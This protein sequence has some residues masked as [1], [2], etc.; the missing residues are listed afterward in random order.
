[1]EEN[2]FDCRIIGSPGLPPQDAVMVV[3]NQL[4]EI[5][6]TATVEFPDM[7][8]YISYQQNGWD[9]ALLFGMI[10]R[11]NPNLAADMPYYISQ[12]SPLYTSLLIPDSYRAAIGAA[13]KTVEME[14]AKMQAIATEVYDNQIV[15]PVFFPCQGDLLVDGLHD[16]GFHT[17]ADMSFTPEICW[18]EESARIQ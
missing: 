4:A 13:L 1:M 15:I 8:K 7:G 11:T 10:S 14:P 16:Y 17:L 3:Q 6:I 5:G 9:N 12:T 2:G 18:L